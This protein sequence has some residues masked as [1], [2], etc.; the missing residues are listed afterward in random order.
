MT[1]A[2]KII[3]LGLSKIAT[4][5]VSSISPAKT[6]L[7]RYMADNYQHWRDAELAGRRWRFA[8]ERAKLT[9]TGEPLDGDPRPNRYL[10]PNDCL[11]PLR[12]NIDGQPATEWEQRG[13]YLYSAYPTLTIE[14]IRRVPEA[15]FD[16]LF[17]EV[18]ACKIAL[19]SAE[20]VTQSNQKKADADAFYTKA[21]NRAGAVNGFTVGSE[22]YE[23]PSKEVGFDFI[24]AR[25]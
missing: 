25:F 11:R 20:Y 5:R 3:N 9:Q 12:D 13:K 18:L 22:Q 15:D 8:V 17:T 4:S 19:E 10:L 6:S 7:E 2:V 14:Y 21:I 23:H 1:T 24:T 16:P